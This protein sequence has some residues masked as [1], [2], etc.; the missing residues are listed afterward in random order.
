MGV[1]M[2]QCL[3]SWWSTTLAASG[4]GKNKETPA[5]IGCIWLGQSFY[6]IT[7]L[8][9]QSAMAPTP[10]P[11]NAFKEAQNVGWFVQRTSLPLHGTMNR[12]FQRRSLDQLLRH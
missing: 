2:L 1:G 10:L 3:T 6:W 8:H 12:A 11:H 9:H 5:E 7:R 4:P